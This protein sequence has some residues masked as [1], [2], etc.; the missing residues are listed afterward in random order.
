VQSRLGQGPEE[1]GGREVAREMGGR[2]N[3]FVGTGKSAIFWGKTRRDGKNL[4]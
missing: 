2:G 4:F 1:I 3:D